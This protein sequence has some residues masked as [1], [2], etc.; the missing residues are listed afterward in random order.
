MQFLAAA[1]HEMRE[2]MRG[3]YAVWKQELQDRK[4]VRS[5]HDGSGKYRDGRP[6]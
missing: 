5:Q 6:Q 2:G 1:L 4:V 3:P